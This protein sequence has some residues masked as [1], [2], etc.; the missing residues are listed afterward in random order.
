MSLVR[1]HNFSIS[2]DGFGAGEPQSLEA[3]FGHAGQKLHQWMMATSFWDPAGSTGVDLAF[4]SRHEVGFGAEIMGANKFGPA[5]WQDDP[6]WRGWWGEDPP[7]HTRRTPRWRRVDRPGLRRGGTGRPAAP[8]PRPDRA[9]SRDPALGRSR[10]TRGL[11]RH[12]GRLLPERRRPPVADAPVPL[13]RG[14][15]GRP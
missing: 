11:L 14:D 3:P 10:G 5:G 9:R 15:F 2:L 7:F 6:A 1:V 13:S 8:G 12:R 4:A